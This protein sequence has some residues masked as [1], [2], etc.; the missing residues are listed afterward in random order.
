MRMTKNNVRRALWVKLIFEPLHESGISAEEFERI[1][2]EERFTDTTL[3]VWVN[4]R[5]PYILRKYGM[6]KLSK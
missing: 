1:C 2:N 5:V 4:E 6:K 3:N